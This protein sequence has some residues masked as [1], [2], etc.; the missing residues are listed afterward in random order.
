MMLLF[1]LLLGADPYVSQVA[2]YPASTFQ[3]GHIDQDMGPYGNSW[4]SNEL[5]PHAV[6]LSAFALDVHEV[7]APAWADFSARL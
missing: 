3:M 1:A 5:P 2:E 7:T 4:K 6:T